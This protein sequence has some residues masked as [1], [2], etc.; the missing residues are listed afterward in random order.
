MIVG[1][2][3]KAFFIII[4]TLVLTL[5]ANAQTNVKNDAPAITP[6]SSYTEWKKRYDEGPWPKITHYGD[7]FNEIK[8]K[9]YRFRS[10]LK[11]S[12]IPTTD[13]KIIT[14]VTMDTA[15]EELFF[16]DIGGILTAKVN[17][18]LRITSADEKIDGVFEGQKDISVPAVDDLNKKGIL[19]RIFIH[20]FDLPPGNYRIRMSASCGYMV[21]PGCS[22][23]TIKVTVP[24]G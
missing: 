4:V 15:T 10:I 22:K 17:Y 2:M 24:A 6:L 7:I 5:F 19:N 1:Y 23:Q 9:D 11:A 16:E 3:N 8:P 14:V 20:S 13:N 18:F 21:L 12:L